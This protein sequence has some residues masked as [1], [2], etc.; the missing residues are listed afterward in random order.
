MRPQPPVTR[1]PVWAR[2][3][4]PAA[5]GLPPSWALRVV[6]ASPAVLSG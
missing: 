4:A 5:G 2:P 3:G 1:Y 6:P